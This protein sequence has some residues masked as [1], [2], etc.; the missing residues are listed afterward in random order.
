MIKKICLPVIA[1]L[2][3]SNTYAQNANL[4]NT[5]D[6]Y[7]R[8]L[9][10]SINLVPSISIGVLYE[11]EVVLEKAYG[12]ANV[13]DKIAAETSTE[14]YIASNTK[15]FTALSASILHQKGKLSFTKSLQ[16]F[17]PE[18]EFSDS[19]HADRITIPMLLSH[20][21]GLDNGDITFLKSQTGDYTDKQLF[22]LLKKSWNRTEMGEFRYTNLGY[23][24]INLI[25]LKEFG[26]SWKEIVQE[27]VLN[28][29][30]MDNTFSSYVEL[31]ESKKPMALAYNSLG[32]GSNFFEEHKELKR[33]ETMQA[34]GGL[35][36]NISDLLKFLQFQVNEGSYDNTNIN[37]A[38]IE[39]TWATR[40][41]GDESNFGLMK[42]ATGY[43]LGWN[44]SE[45]SNF[46][47]FHHGGAFGGFRSYI[48]FIPE[49]KS[50]VVVMVNDAFTGNI[51]N[52]QLT[53][54]VL[55]A[56]SHADDLTGD[57]MKGHLGFL[58]MMKKEVEMNA[59]PMKI[60][61]HLII[62]HLDFYFPSILDLSSQ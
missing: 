31:L 26:K 59:I 29:M 48:S 12:F 21:S 6:S 7:V 23:N 54:F 47:I 24:I 35:Y 8:Q 3:C 60:V 15:A 17:F 36:S 62:I 55:D 56:I 44:I 40:T 52:T 41:S 19:I 9:M 57:W 58:S 33:D 16:E 61:H 51:V 10:D 2:I 43:S 25:Y 53:M 42:Y 27:E 32:D 13:E 11:G 22:D 20:T 1:F 39:D 34:A 46:K 28:P 18:I 14:Y 30:G 4:S 45:Y 38:A 49:N 5:I 50:G 37:K